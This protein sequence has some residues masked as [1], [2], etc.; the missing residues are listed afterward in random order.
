MAYI[1]FSLLLIR[2]TNLIDYV[3]DAKNMGIFKPFFVFGKDASASIC[4]NL[5]YEFSH[6]FFGISASEK[7][8]YAQIMNPV[9]NVE[10]ILIDYNGC[11]VRAKRLTV[12]SEIPIRIDTAW[13][14]V[15]TPA[16]LLFVAKGMMKLKSVDGPFPKQWEAEKTYAIKTRVFGLIPFGGI[17]YLSIVKIDDNNLRSLP[18]NGIAERKFGITT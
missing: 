10:S 1:F 13:N 8:A 5:I 2:F 16:L 18:K 7:N 4:A 6:S 14:N 15:K 9:A 3:I 11:K 17:H 12:H